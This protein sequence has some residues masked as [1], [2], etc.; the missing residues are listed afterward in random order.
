MCEIKIDTQLHLQITNYACIANLLEEY[1]DT[2]M[3]VTRPRRLL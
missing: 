3:T 2:A 1:K